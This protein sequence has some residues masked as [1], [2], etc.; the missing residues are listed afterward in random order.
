MTTKN[1]SCG[2]LILLGALLAQTVPMGH[3][4]DEP[5]QIMWKDLVPP[6]PADYVFPKLSKQQAL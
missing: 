2:F 4:A 1:H 3:A 6:L 5:R